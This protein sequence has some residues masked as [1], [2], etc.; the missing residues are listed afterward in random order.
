MSERVVVIV[1]ARMG[2]TRLPGKS[3]KK[4]LDK[5]LFGYVGERLAAC[6][7]VSQ[8]VIATTT[9]PL[10]DPIADYCTA[11]DIACFRGSEE[12]VLQ[13][14]QGAAEKFHADVI[15]RVTGDCPLTDPAIVDEAVRLFRSGHYDY[16]S[17]VI[18]RTYPRGF[19][20]EVFS[21][22]ALEKAAS[23]AVNPSEREHVTPYIHHHPELFRIGDLSCAEDTSFYRL[24]VD[25]QEDFELV[26]K[27]I[28]ELFPKNPYFSLQDVL[29]L[30]R[31]HPDWAQINAHIKQKEIG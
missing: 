8:F 14:Y 17:N 13:R 5:P 26:S 7:E 31:K 16:V 23:S 27:I 12:D 2:S 21:K 25:H 20:V 1:Q 28:L 3:L 29:R 9:S 6:K 19:D 4:I 30:L 11:H 15:V 18:K 22:N 24:T 10:D